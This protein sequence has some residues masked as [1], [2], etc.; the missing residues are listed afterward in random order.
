MKD[1]KKEPSS[2]QSTNQ[3]QIHNLEIFYPNFQLH[4]KHHEEK[5]YIFPKK[6]YLLTYITFLLK[7]LI[8]IGN[9]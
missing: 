8:R 9:K 2:V 6:P 1:R 4:V 7:D 3:K 5:L